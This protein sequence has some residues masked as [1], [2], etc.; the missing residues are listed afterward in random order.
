MK[1]RLLFITVLILCMLPSYAQKHRNGAN[2]KEKRK[3]FM[4]FKLDFLSKELDLKEDQKKQFYEVYTQM[5]SE[6]RAVFKKIKQAE[7]SVRENKDASDADYEKASKEITAAKN[8]MMQLEK[9]Y[10]EKFAT[11]LSK[12]QMFKLKEAESAFNQRMQECKEKKKP[13]K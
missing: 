1:T 9:Q 12:K 10:D 11:F 2:D 4:E 6:R 8:E 7:K 5:E 13:K 3:E